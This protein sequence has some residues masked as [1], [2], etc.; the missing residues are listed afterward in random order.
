MWSSLQGAKSLGVTLPIDFSANADVLY[1]S[2]KDT[3]PAS[4]PGPGSGSSSVGGG[5]MLVPLLVGAIVG[6]MACLAARK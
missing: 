4:G 2:A 1:E 3:A 5:G 6:W